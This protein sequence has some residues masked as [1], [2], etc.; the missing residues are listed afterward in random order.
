MDY[1]QQTLEGRI[2]SYQGNKYQN[3][4]TLDK[5]R[6]ESGEKLI[7]IEELAKVEAE[8][9]IVTGKMVEDGFYLTTKLFVLV[10]LGILS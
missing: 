7:E 10:F 8:E 4:S 2:G 9:G 3:E 1:P 5:D 6:F